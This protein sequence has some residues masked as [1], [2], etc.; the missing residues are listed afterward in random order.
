MFAR[1]LAVIV[2]ILAFATACSGNDTVARD[3]SPATAPPSSSPALSCDYQP[4]PAGA[5]KNASPPPATP[6][7][8][9]RVAVTLALTTGKVPVVLDA[10]AAPCTVGSFV[11]LADQGY[12]DGTKCHRLTTQGIFVLQCGDPLATGMGGPGYTI[13]DELTGSEAYP[14]GTLAMAN[15]GAPHTGGSQFFIVYADTG[16]PPSYTVFGRLT[17]RGLKVV[18]EIAA[19]GTADGGPDGA[20]KEQVVVRA[21]RTS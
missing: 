3:S 12:F 6:T 16:L 14:A 17:P 9:G 7:V 11:S 13:P 8:S 5:A 19:Q 2:C 21:V 18:Q 1:P 15:A 20:P 10:D 4:D